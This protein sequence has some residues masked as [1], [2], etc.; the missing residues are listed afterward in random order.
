MSTRTMRSAKKRPPWSSLP[1]SRGESPRTYRPDASVS[2]QHAKRGASIRPPLL[3]SLRSV[4][5]GPPRTHMPQ[6]RLIS[7]KSTK[8]HV[9]MSAMCNPLRRQRWWDVTHGAGQEHCS[10]F[11]ATKLREVKSVKREAHAEAAKSCLCADNLDRLSFLQFSIDKR[12][13][14]AFENNQDRRYFP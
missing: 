7:T 6:M 13:A 9:M 2:S 10:C 14:F 1:Q 11:S 4:S 3:A 8:G 12:I 5:V